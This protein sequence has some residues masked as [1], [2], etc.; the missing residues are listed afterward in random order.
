M[1]AKFFQT[2]GERIQGQ[3]GTQKAFGTPIEVHDKVLLPVA[4]V[5][6]AFG[7][8]AGMVN[9]ANAPEGIG[10]GGAGGGGAAVIAPLGVIEITK[11]ETRFV[12]TDDWRKWSQVFVAGL[13]AGL[14]L[15]RL[16]RNKKRD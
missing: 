4:R 2:L 15:R 8:G 14:V 7:G 10:Q 12:P 6:F 13:M 5:S 11:H 16:L 1:I 9:A 3:A